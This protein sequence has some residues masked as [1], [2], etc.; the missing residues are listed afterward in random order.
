MAATAA[1]LVADFAE[2]P[3]NKKTFFCC[4]SILCIKSKMNGF[5]R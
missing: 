4:N 1:N 3:H 2:Q 5:M